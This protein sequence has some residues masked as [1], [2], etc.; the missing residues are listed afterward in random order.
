MSGVT[1]RNGR[2]D[3]KALRNLTVGFR[4]LLYAIVPANLWPE[5]TKFGAAPGEALHERRSCQ[6]GLGV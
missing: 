4:L 5:Y 3:H 6:G 1:A 2:L